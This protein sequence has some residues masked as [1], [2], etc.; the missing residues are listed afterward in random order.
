M[1]DGPI[2]A[3]GEYAIGVHLHPDVDAEVKL[4]IVAEE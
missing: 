4:R 1:P 2:H 3:L